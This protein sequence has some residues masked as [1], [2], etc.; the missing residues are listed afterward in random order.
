[1]ANIIKNIKKTILNYHK[2]RVIHIK[3]KGHVKKG[4]ILISYTIFPFIMSERMLKST[5]H[6][7]I[8]EAKEIVRIFTEEGFDVDYI[9]YENVKFHPKKDYVAIIDIYNN[10]ERLIPF[11]N[12]DCLKIAHITA[13]H[14]KFQN[15]AEF[16]RLRRIKERTGIEL[17]PRRIS[18]EHKGIDLCD[19]ATMLGN[20]YTISTYAYAGKEIYKLPLSHTTLYE[21]NPNKNYE[22]VKKNFL[23]IGGVGLAHKGLDLV[24]EAFRQLPQYTLYVC[25]DINGEQ[26]F[27]ELYYDDLYSSPNVKTIG[28]ID[29][30]SDKF[31]KVIDDC[32]S[33]IYPSCAEGCAGSVVNS[34][35]AGLI[36]IISKES[37]VDVEDFGY[38]LKENNIECIIQKITELSALPSENL[39]VLSQKAW[40]YA[41]N[42]Y[43]KEN[44]SKEYQ[45]F[46]KNK[47]LNA[48]K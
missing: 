14:W 1:M 21:I 30:A 10:L 2:N 9:H 28:W 20:E 13:S 36:P 6:S 11:L 33:L 31:L 5:S 46:V 48:I 26:D 22:K 37:G 15:D 12:K 43:T 44:F 25:G 17:Q 18:E 41:R 29:T 16:D 27:K 40:R 39:R 35:H 19:F 32:V 24:L 45:L 23:W 38:I 34:M 47:V 4:N 42:I 8:Y 3:H 7:N